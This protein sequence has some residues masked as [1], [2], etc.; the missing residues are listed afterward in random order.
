MN[1]TELIIGVIKIH[2]PKYSSD[3]LQ[4]R[5][6][7]RLDC[8]F[9]IQAQR[10]DDL[11]KICTGLV[12]GFQFRADNLRNNRLNIDPA[13]IILIEQ[14]DIYQVFNYHHIFQVHDLSKKVFSE[15]ENRSKYHDP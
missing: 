4:D 8:I 14:T 10:T 6:F 1:K 9:L 2:T 5:S 7:A 12:I 13:F 11:D 3:H 15:P